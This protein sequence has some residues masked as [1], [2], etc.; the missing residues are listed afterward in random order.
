MEPLIAKANEEFLP[1]PGPPC[2][3]AMIAAPS[4][5]DR[6]LRGADGRRRRKPELE[7]VAA[8]VEVGG[9]CSAVRF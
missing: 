6:Y 1:I 9:R 8:D 4:G 3:R 7:I 2:E 5:N